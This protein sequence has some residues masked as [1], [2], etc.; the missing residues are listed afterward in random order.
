M[1]VASARHLRRNLVAYVALLFALGGTSYAAATTL[2]PPNSVGTRQVING[3]LLKKDFK[4]GQLPRGARGPRGPVGAAGSTGPAGPA[5]SAGA[6]GATGA[7]GAAGAP[8]APGPAGT[9]RAYGLVDATGTSVTRSK[10]V[11]SVSTPTAGEYCITLD[12]GVSFASTG[13]VAIPDWST[14]GTSGT[15]ITHVEWRTSGN[16]C[17][18][19]Q[20]DILTF[21]VT[22]ATNLV[23]TQ[24]AEPFFF[25]VP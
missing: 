16:G 12:S 4:A 5:G 24:T 25:I 3:S 23:N 13:V 2:L 10:N 21:E 1:W 11:V 7:T 6:T 17:A 8:G 20:V 18:A 15:S 22:A 9:A 19:G 14:D